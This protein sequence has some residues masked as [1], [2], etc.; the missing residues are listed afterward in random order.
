MKIRSHELP[1]T[2]FNEMNELIVE[3]PVSA[4]RCCFAMVPDAPAL[5][6]CLIG[7]N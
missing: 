4:I 6:T 5:E 3:P 2:C 1:N 7:I